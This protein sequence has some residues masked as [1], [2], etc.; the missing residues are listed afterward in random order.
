LL[1]FRWVGMKEKH[2][3]RSRVDVYRDEQ[4]EGGAG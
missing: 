4:A 3:M 1:G 2:P